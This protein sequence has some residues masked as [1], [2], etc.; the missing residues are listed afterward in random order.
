MKKRFFPSLVLAL[1]ICII[2]ALTAQADTKLDEIETYNITVDMEDDASMDITYH[3][4]WKVLD[5]TREGPLSWVKIG[6]PNDSV[7][8]IMAL[9]SNI[10]S[11][12]YYYDGG[13]Y[14]RIDLDREYYADEVV[15]LDFSIRVPYMYKANFDSNLCSY[16]FTPGW[17][18]KIDVK[19]M[20]ILWNDEN[21]LHSDATT[22]QGNYL[23][24][25]TSLAAGETFSVYVEYSM[26]AFNTDY[27]DPPYVEEPSYE[28]DGYYESDYDS[29]N[30]G[31]WI[32]AVVV[33]FVIIPV[34][35]IRRFGGG[36]DGYRGGFG[37]RGGFIGGGGGHCACASSCA[38]ACACA[39]AGGGRAGCSAKN[40]YGAVKTEAL[41]HALQQNTKHD[42]V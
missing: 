32:I 14:V 37:G 30:S 21:V 3:I 41:K 10:S 11:I 2:P 28:D 25:T 29:G 33:I 24:W 27:A 19:S 36:D 40:F 31:G 18:E 22:S 8:T 7:D 39:C 38:C 34:I 42:R 12:Y 15:P 20:T 23:Q 35:V 5:D 6:I 9:S 13:D 17:F 4:D 16:Y 1:L 26:D